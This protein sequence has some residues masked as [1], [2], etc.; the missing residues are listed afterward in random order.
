M[1]TLDEQEV[2]ILI[3]ATSDH[4]KVY[5]SYP[6][7]LRKF[8]KMCEEN[9]DEWKCT[10]TS[11]VDGEAVGKSYECPKKL[12][13]FKRTGKISEKRREANIRALQIAR[14]RTGIKNQLR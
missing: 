3:E 13:T 4:A 11:K 5:T 14:G 6:A 10:G 9:P 12:I 7:Y 1:L 8:D 2:S